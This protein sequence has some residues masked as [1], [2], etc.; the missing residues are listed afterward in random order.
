MLHTDFSTRDNP[1][2][3]EGLSPIVMVTIVLIGLALLGLFLM[4]GKKGAAATA[5]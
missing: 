4:F 2:G 1:K 5:T 3:S